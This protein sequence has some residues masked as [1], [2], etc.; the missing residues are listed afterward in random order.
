VPGAADCD[1]LKKLFPEGVELARF[2]LQLV[3]I[4]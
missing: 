4:E 1:R 3:V 2:S